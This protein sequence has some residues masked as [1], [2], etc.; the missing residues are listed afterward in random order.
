[1][2]IYIMRHGQA[3]LMASSDSE[4][5]LTTQGRFE[6]EQM[7][8]YLANQ[9]VFFDTS[10]LVYLRSPLLRL[11]LLASYGHCVKELAVLVESGVSVISAIAI[12]NP[13]T[14]TE[15]GTSHPTPPPP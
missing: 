12:V 14:Q 1:M 3:E 11:L 13:Q 7:A 10:A 9:N 5:A 8:T 6:S 15:T 2:Q 4:R